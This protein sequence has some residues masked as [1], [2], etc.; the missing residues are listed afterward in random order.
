VMT[1]RERVAIAMSGGVDSST[2]AVLLKDQGYDLVGFSMQLW[3]QKRNEAGGEHLHTGRCC[4]LDDI[5]D[6]RSVA[7][8]LKI[9]YY[10][11]NFQKEFEA[12]VVK[13]FIEGYRDGSTP[14]PC[15]L[16]NSHLKF[17]HLLRMAEEVNASRVATGHY[18][19][20]QY[21]R[22]T[23]RHLLLRARDLNKDQSYF[24]FELTQAQLSRAIFPL[25][26]LG[27]AE[28]RQ[29]ARRQ[30]L[31]VADK[32]ESQE[33]CF[34]PDGDYAGFIERHYNEVVG[35]GGMEANPFPAGEIVDV[36]GRRLGRHSGIHRFTI[37]QRRGLGIAHSEP[38]YVIEIRPGS[39]QV[40]VG[41][42]RELAQK[43]CRVVRS[44]WISCK[45]PEHTVR[46]TARIRSRHPDSP[47]TVSPLKDGSYGVEFDHPQL[48]IS[49]GQACVF[50]QG[51]QVLGGGWIAR[52]QA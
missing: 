41:S 26:D 46:A 37:G 34:V 44:N 5:Y 13:S 22:E 8:R 45:A 52:S 7:S 42:R 43:S 1:V 36:Q 25:G 33:I 14:S 11:V 16:C 47:A 17:D 20:V 19:R 28:V 18:A 2:A 10:V 49:P 39:K 9:P 38:L 51:E 15:V 3:D 50:Y 12:R 27:K 30:G 29:L 35:N 4:S 31:E 21:D 23:G 48:A 40:V 24:L 32:P 6:A